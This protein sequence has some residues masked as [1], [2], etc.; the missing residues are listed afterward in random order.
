MGTAGSIG[1]I[2]LI[3]NLVISYK[4]FKDFA[5]YQKSTF[6]VDA[7]LVGKDYK[8]LISSGF[9]HVSWMHLIFNMISLYAF[10]EAVEYS[11]GGL[12]FVLLY[13][14]SL[15]GG[16]LFSLY[17]HRNHGDYSAVG[18]SG[19][20]SGVIFAAIALVPGM[21]LSLLFIPI[22]I[23]SWL[24]GLVFVCVSIWGIKS[25]K[26]NIGHDAHLGGGLVGLCFAIMLYPDVLKTNPLPIALIAIPSALFIYLILTRPEILI[27]NSF[28]KKPKYYSR[29]DRFNSQR[30]EKQETLDKLL[31]KIS[32]KGIDSLS[33]KE[34]E[35]LKR[36]S[37]GDSEE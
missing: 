3:A 28:N 24:F 10:S 27:I 16:N 37:G 11:V 31:D 17:L 9:V 7:I 15:L 30:K 19:A 13:F 33:K 18:A 1:L 36:L 35:T 5:F 8:R 4:A 23:P 2:I 14:G 25:Q 26:G 29:D 21:E 32:E 20:V 6:R 34:K 22:G 12:N